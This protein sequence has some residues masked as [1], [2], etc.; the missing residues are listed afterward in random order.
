M[1]T[2]LIADHPNLLYNVASVYGINSV[3]SKWMIFL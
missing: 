3:I 2:Y 1:G